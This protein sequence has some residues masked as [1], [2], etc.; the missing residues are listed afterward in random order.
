M[1]RA[2]FIQRTQSIW[3]P[4]GTPA[5]ISKYDYTNDALGRRTQVQYTGV[6]FGSPDPAITVGFGYNAR[7]ELTSAD[8]SGTDPNDWAYAYDDIGN[9]RWS[10]A[11]DPTIRTNYVSNE[12]N[13]YHR[14]ER[15]STPKAAQ[16]YRY[17]E[18]GNLIE[19]YTSGDMHCN[20]S[21]G[22]EDI[23]CFV[24]VIVDGCCPDDPNGRV[25]RFKVVRFD[26]FPALD[27][28]GNPKLNK[29]SA[30]FARTR[31]RLEA[32]I[33]DLETQ[34]A[35]V[36]DDATLANI[37]LQNVLQ[38]QRQAIQIISNISKTWHDMAMAAIQNIK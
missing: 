13:Q 19:R 11:G 16:G 20:G 3:D 8:R 29:A 36:G 22:Y 5:T 28:H 30:G 38:K 10:D 14:S 21:V 7:N 31:G 33:R 1:L 35:T 27:R 12:L 9:R 6:A 15:A 4:N 17:D 26:T 23:N 18:D 24:Q 37:D 2:L 32:Y 34:L 25:D